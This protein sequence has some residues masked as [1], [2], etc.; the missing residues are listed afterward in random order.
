[1]CSSCVSVIIQFSYQSCIKGG[2]Q[3][4]GT[5]PYVYIQVNQ[6]TDVHVREVNQMA[7]VK[8]RDG[9]M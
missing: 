9:E 3:R 1:M 2:P 7:G 6:I 8:K 5:P 4:N